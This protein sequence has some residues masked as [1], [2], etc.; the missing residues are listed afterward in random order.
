MSGN[1][2]IF[3]TI[4]AFLIAITGAEDPYGIKEWNVTY[5]DIYRL[6]VR[7]QIKL[8]I[9]GKDTVKE[10]DFDELTSNSI[11]TDYDISSMS[12]LENEA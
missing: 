4:G 2:V 5:G 11:V 9:A 1:L 8:S 7:Q 6:G 12:G 3:F 10:D